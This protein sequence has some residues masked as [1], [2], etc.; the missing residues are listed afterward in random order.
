MMA[1]IK[2][3]LMQ[4]DLILNV[5]ASQGSVCIT[6]GFRTQLCASDSNDPYFIL[7]QS[8]TVPLPEQD[9]FECSYA[10][11]KKWSMACAILHF[12]GGDGGIRTHDLR[13]ANAA[14]SQLS[15][16]PG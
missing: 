10:P 1:S 7:A 5:L 15:Y 3:M 16:T 9:G 14:L 12:F 4:S 11:A 13:V 2:Y 8:S 6:V